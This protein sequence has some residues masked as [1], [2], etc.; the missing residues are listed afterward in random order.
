[1]SHQNQVY[2]IV[3]SLNSFKKIII[4]NTSKKNIIE[5]TLKTIFDGYNVEINYNK[6]DPHDCIQLERLDETKQTV[7]D[8]IKKCVLITH[9]K[10]QI[11]RIG[12][13]NCLVSG[14]EINKKFNN[15]KHLNSN[16]YNVSMCIIIVF[17]GGTFFKCSGYADS[18]QISN[19]KNINSAFQQQPS[20][21]DSEIATLAAACHD[22][23][24]KLNNI[25]VFNTNDYLKVDTVIIFGTF[26]LFHDLHKRL[27]DHAFLIGKKVIINIY[28]KKFKHKNNCKVKICDS[29]RKRITTIT[30]YA[31]I[32]YKNIVV[33][34]M[35]DS[36]PTELK[37][38]IE[39][40]SKQ[41]SV[42]IMGGDDQFNDYESIVSICSKMKTPI[43]A[44]NR[45]ETKLKL[46]SSDVREKISYQRIA[47]IHDLDL[48]KISMVFWKN[49]FRNVSD[50]KIYL[51]TKLNFLGLE[52]AEIRKFTPLLTV[53][54]LV[55]KSK[56][57]HNKVILCLPGRTPCSLDR[58]RKIA[59]T[60]QNDFLPKYLHMNASIYVGCYEQNNYDTE[61]HISK[62]DHDPDYFSDDAMIFTK[63]LIMPT[64]CN[65]LIIEKNDNQWLITQNNK[66]KSIDLITKKLSNITL[67]VRSIGSIIAL[68]MENAFKY[69]MTNLGF[70]K[71]EIITIANKISVLS[72]CNL[73]ALDRPRLFNTVS[74]TGINDK[75]AQ[76]YISSPIIKNTLI[77]NEYASFT[78]LNDTHFS[79]LATIP[80]K[81]VEIGS[82]KEIEDDNCHYTPLF[83]AFRKN[84]NNLIPE[85]IR[86]TFI[87]MIDR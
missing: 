86:E 67:F 56:T 20:N 9:S 58:A 71:N 22:A 77:T 12:A 11:F 25:H 79:V 85:Y 74:I 23:L 31:A 45:G 2:A 83:T 35:L 72:I 54:K 44:L 38:A 43:I 4:E 32:G 51:R 19:N 40:Y 81:I 28:N 34:R 27:I 50:A 17:K 26:D 6:I 60:I 1:M 82:N 49:H 7:S 18:L 64:I 57:D 46:C 14:Y 10:Q 48:D 80:Q 61:Y 78:K 52:S 5:N 8:K 69:C 16:W 24:T 63:L 55:V 62:L 47:D 30:K 37:R 66:L 3:T 36:H 13:A 59:L 53:D 75:K 21:D 84:D 76:K 65:K 15:D 87:E 33:R 70:I 73:A 68:E 39:I 41:G 42:A 29:M